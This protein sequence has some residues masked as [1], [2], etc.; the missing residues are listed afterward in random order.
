[1]GPTRYCNALALSFM[2]SHE[3]LG[4]CSRTVLG[5][6]EKKRKGEVRDELACGN[7]PNWVLFFFIYSFLL[8][9]FN[10][11]LNLSWKFRN[12]NLIY[13]KN[14]Q[15][16]MQYIFIFYTA[17]IFKWCKYVVLTQ[18]LLFQK[19]TICPLFKKSLHQNQYYLF[20]LIE[21]IF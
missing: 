9:C 14:S 16:W 15:A 19:S 17:F 5:E 18:R 20:I 3:G 21:N 1:M 4:R 7:H 10:S 12:S 2:D 6:R 11:N 8:F 13:Q